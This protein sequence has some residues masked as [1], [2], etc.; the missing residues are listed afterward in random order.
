MRSRAV[1][2]VMLAAITG[3]ATIAGFSAIGIAQVAPEEEPNRADLPPQ[4]LA[5]AREA[6]LLGD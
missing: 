4:G 3:L 1:P 2:V 6:R 5:L